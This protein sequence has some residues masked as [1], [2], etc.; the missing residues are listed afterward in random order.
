VTSSV[1]LTSEEEMILSEMEVD[2]AVPEDP[3]RIAARLKE[4]KQSF[5]DEQRSIFDEI[6]QSVVGSIP[7]LGQSRNGPDECNQRGGHHPAR[8]LWLEGTV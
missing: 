4:S 7:D 1:A 5:T 2:D 6:T 3:A 8:I